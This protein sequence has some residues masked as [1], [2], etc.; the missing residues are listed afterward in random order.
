MKF[1]CRDFHYI[2][3]FYDK[4][5]FH[6]L[7]KQRAYN[8]SEFVASIGGLIGLIAG[9]SMMSL[10]EILYFLFYDSCLKFSSL[11]STSTI[12][13]EDL[14]TEREV[15]MAWQGETAMKKFLNYF[16]KFLSI[17]N[18]DGVSMIVKKDHSIIGNIF[19]A[20]IVLSSI[21]FCCYFIKDNASYAELNPVAFEVDEKLWSVE[22]VRF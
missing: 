7:V 5:S 12:Q 21:F 18:I 3:F 11:L 20:F 6:A 8:F 9:V 16:K 2:D 1:I 17:S 22:E 19:W 10:V 14:R 4:S 15:F 13:P